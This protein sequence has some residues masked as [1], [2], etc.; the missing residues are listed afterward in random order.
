MTNLN[1]TTKKAILPG[2]NRHADWQSEIT[3][4]TGQAS[5]LTDCSWVC[6]GGKDSVLRWVLLPFRSKFKLSSTYRYYCQSATTTT[7]TCLNSRYLISSSVPG[8][9]AWAMVGGPASNQQSQYYCSTLDI[10]SSR[11]SVS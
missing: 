5:Q 4:N 2:R 10:Q 7:A 3:T 9:Q 1:W 6:R 8:T 11:H